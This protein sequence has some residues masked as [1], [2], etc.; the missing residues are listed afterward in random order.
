MARF[1]FAQPRL[2]SRWKIRQPLLLPVGGAVPDPADD[3][4]VAQPCHPC[5]VRGQLGDARQDLLVRE[6]LALVRLPG[7]QRVHAAPPQRLAYQ[8]RPELQQ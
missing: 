7:G 6:R 5:R 2:P 3:Q 4:R 8:G 1:Q